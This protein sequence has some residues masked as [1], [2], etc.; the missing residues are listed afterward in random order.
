MRRL[1]IIALLLCSCFAGAL[2]QT[3]SSEWLAKLRSS[4]GSRYAWNITVQSGGEQF[5]GY[6]IVDGD[7]YYLTLGAMEVYSD[8]KLRYEVNNARQ[9]VTEDRVNLKAV[10]L[11]TNPTRAFSFLDKEYSIT[12]KSQSSSG[13]VL[14]LLP[15][16][17]DSELSEISLELAKSGGAVLPRRIVYNYDGDTISIELQ[18][19]SMAGVTL[20]RWSK[21]SYRAYDIVSFL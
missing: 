14:R 1:I 18:Q 17:D 12:L 10:D 4:L 15:K 2:A 16:G 6:Y 7:G 5:V 19:R 3:T 20:P 8:G 11:L 13:V 9:E 21:E